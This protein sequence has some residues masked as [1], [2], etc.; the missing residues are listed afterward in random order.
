MLTIPG[1]FP[2]GLRG[3]GE[4]GIHYTFLFVPLLRLL[5]GG[6]RA[7]EMAPWFKVITALP[8]GPV[9]IPT[10]YLVARNHR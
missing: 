3:P 2:Q 5:G 10:T 6:G 4:L 1:R 7:G 8:E 9:L